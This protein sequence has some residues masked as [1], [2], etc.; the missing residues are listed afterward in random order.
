MLRE[1]TVVID[2]IERWR[3]VLGECG[4]GVLAVKTL[5]IAIDPNIVNILFKR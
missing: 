2:G 1:V 5:L 4:M 3:V